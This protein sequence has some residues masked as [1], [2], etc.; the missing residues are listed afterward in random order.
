MTAL[1]AA[2]HVQAQQAAPEGLAVV[3]QIGVGQGHAIDATLDQTVQEDT[4][5]IQALSLAEAAHEA[6]AEAGIV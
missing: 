1:L 5:C 4:T 6:E 2:A 3:R